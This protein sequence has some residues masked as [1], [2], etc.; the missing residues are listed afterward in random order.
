MK[1][2]QTV[3]KVLQ[4]ELTFVILHAIMI[5]LRGKKISK[6]TTY[7]QGRMYREPQIPK[8]YFNSYNFLSDAWHIAINDGNLRHVPRNRQCARQV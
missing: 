1:S 4:S 8:G 7:F 5:R 2:L 6:K 3:T